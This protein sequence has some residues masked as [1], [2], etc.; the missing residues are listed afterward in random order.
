MLWGAHG[1]EAALL[2]RGRPH[3]E[4]HSQGW[5][6]TAAAL[7]WLMETSCGSQ[8]A[9]GTGPGRAARGSGAGGPGGGEPGKE[10]GGGGRPRLG[11]S[12]L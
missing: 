8:R 5:E 2:P 12:G 11:P 3:A 10:S 7:I 6:A 4:P 1:A 9:A